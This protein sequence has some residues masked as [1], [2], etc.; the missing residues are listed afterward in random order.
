MQSISNFYDLASGWESQKK[1]LVKPTTMAAYMLIIRKHILP[2]FNQITKFTAKDVQAFID[3]KVKEGL[4]V[5]SIKDINTVLRMIM[6][7]AKNQGFIVE[8]LSMIRYPKDIIIKDIEVFSVKQEKKLIDF[9]TTNLSCKNMGLL[10]CLFTGL[11][12]GEICALKWS[13]IDFNKGVININKTLYRIYNIY[14]NEKTTEII[15]S[16]PKTKHS[17]RNIP[18][19]DTLLKAMTSFLKNICEDSYL[20]TNKT[21]PMEPRTYRNY[22]KRILQILALPELK[23]HSL[24]HTFATRCIESGC[25]YKTVSVILGHADISTTMD[26]YVHPGFERKKQCLEKMLDNVCS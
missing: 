15:M 21:K 8:D 24:R 4:S 12:I 2:Y 13:D 22:Y 10:I 25:D 16:S 3:M 6:K 20:L 1:N 18:L 17:F 26:L 19:P 11:R 7:Y 5:K 9:L 14:N 23:F